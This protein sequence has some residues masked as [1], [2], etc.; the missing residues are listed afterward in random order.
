MTM[1]RVEWYWLMKWSWK[2]WPRLAVM[3][4]DSTYMFRNVY[5]W[6]FDFGPLRI[7]RLRERE[8]R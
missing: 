8:A 3:A 1:L 5:R 6:V 4:P 2:L 7:I